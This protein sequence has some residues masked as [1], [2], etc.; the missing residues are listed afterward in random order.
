M[1]QLP[2]GTAEQA[3]AA[4]AHFLTASRSFP[5]LQK[6]SH[7]VQGSDAAI[8]AP[9]LQPLMTE[10]AWT[11]ST[12]HMN[13]GII[14]QWHPAGNPVAMLSINDA[15]VAKRLTPDENGYTFVH[16]KKTPTIMSD[17]SANGITQVA[18][19][20]VIYRM[21]FT[22]TLGEAVGVQMEMRYVF[23]PGG[24]GQWKF[25][26][27]DGQNFQY[28]IAATQEELDKMPAI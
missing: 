15:A 3:Q 13:N 22:N 7:P 12:T 17:Q 16:A 21:F 19:D 25:S 24:D 27:W 18:F 1:D 9:L 14:P 8:I 20:K 10:R 5:E 2:A 28:S 6:G 26:D 11:Q 4:L 23:A